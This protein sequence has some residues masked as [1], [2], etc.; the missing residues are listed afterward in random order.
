M[1]FSPGTSGLTILPTDY[2][3]YNDPL[4][5]YP[6]LPPWTPSAAYTPTGA[7][8]YN[9]TYI[10]WKLTGSM[11]PGTSGSVTFTVRIR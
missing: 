10:A 5:V 11:P 2:K 3:Y 4:A 6:L 1:I 9:V 8:D 7:F